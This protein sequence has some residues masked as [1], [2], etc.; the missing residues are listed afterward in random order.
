MV[1][2]ATAYNLHAGVAVARSGRG[3]VD[4][5]ILCRFRPV[6]GGRTK[7]NKKK[8][9][10]EGAVVTRRARRTAILGDLRVTTAPSAFRD[11]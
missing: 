7:T 1:P 8:M 9:N 5:R 11:R 4:I 2:G 10:A 3:C 6:S